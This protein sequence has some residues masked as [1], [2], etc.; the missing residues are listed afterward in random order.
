MPPDS[1]F[2][3]KDLTTLV[4]WAKFIGT[5]VSI[6]GGLAGLLVIYFTK[7]LPWYRARRRSRILEDRVGAK[8]YTKGIIEQ[9]IRYYIEPECQDLDPSGRENPKLLVGV[10]QNLFAAVD[11]MLNNPTEYRYFLLLADSGMGKTSFVIN[12]YARNL[13]HHKKANLVILPLGIP[14]VDERIQKIEDKE[15]KILFLDAFDED[16]L[17]IVDHVERL[18]TLMELTKSFEKIIITC[19][20]QFFPRDEEIPKETGIV[21][22]GPKKAGEG[23]KYVFHKLYLS[24]FTDQQITQYLKKRYPFGQKKRRRKAREMVAR[25]PDLGVR[26]MLLAHIDDLVETNREINYG[27]ELYEEMVEAWLTREEKIIEDLKKDHLRQFSERLAVDLYVNRKQRGAERIHYDQ[28]VPLA[29]DWNIPLDDWQLRGRSLLNRDADGNYKFAHRS[30]MEY[31]FVKR[32]MD[33]KSNLRPD[34]EW[35]DQ[36][37]RFFVEMTW[38]INP[39][40]LKANGISIVD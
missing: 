17:A 26:P 38:K 10:R 4:D 24:L 6:L 25:I 35:T 40:Y 19:R 30:I 8:V 7:I 27:F 9:A 28:L 13:F 2:F 23:A 32:V 15:N 29:R 14:D 1:T 12:Y 33:G 22:I 37:Q 5:I 31:L 16:T 20:T 39:S 34:M 36:M 21:K 3:T 11:N 18:K